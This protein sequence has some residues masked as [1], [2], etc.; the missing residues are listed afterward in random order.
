MCYP[1]SAIRA[2]LLVHFSDAKMTR[3]QELEHGYNNY[4]KLLYYTYL[5]TRGLVGFYIQLVTLFR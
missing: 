5:A 3:K 1:L 4:S 2:D